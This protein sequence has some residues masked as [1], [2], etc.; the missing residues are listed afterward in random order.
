[1]RTS[2]T[3]L[4][5]ELIIPCSCRASIVKA[6]SSVS[7][8]QSS[9]IEPA[10]PNQTSTTEDSID[11]SLGAA[12]PCLHSSADSLQDLQRLFPLVDPS[13]PGLPITLLRKY[14]FTCKAC[15]HVFMR[16]R[17]DTHTRLCPTRRTGRSG[18]DD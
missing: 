18:E 10:S 7:D 2:S 15:N 14:L 11:S 4:V 16:S 13:S 12:Y 9:D 17:R 1:M 8:Q 5:P 3:S 6:A